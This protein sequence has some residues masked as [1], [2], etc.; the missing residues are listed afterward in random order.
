M[1]LNSNDIF[2][3]STPQN[4]RNTEISENTVA[5]ISATWSL[6]LEAILTIEEYQTMLKQ[7][8]QEE[9]IGISPTEDNSFSMGKKITLN[10]ET[11]IIAKVTTSSTQRVPEFEV[12]V[13]KTIPGQ[14]KRPNT[15]SLISKFGAPNESYT[16]ISP[17]LLPNDNS[18][19]ILINNG[20]KAFSR[21]EISLPNGETT[22]F[23]KES[24]KRN[25]LSQYISIQINDCEEG[26]TLC[27]RLTPEKVGTSE[28]ITAELDG[29]PADINLL[30]KY[31]PMAFNVKLRGNN[32][33]IEH[34]S[35]YERLRHIIST[36][37]SL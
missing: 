31:L 37:E 30:H 23:W 8:V 25:R 15:I 28:F 11:N 5:L 13:N 35:I 34:T 4:I 26:T 17:L 3:A 7:K 6:M 2:A 21:D 32:S 16:P 12:A 36:G 1:S 14:G 22:L 20:S 29:Q 19:K 9:G 27:I 10:N 18:A 33:E 24:D